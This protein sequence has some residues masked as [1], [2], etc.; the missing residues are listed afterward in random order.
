[1]ISLDLM[2]L[3]LSGLSFTWKG[4]RN[5]TL[6]DEH[7][8]RG[9]INRQWQDLWPNIMVTHGMVLGSDHY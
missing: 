2:D 9:L 7:L 3:D 5:G 4:I 1:M 8:D 6:V